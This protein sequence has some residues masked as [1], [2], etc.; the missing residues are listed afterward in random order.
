MRGQTVLP[1]V[2][3]E[4]IYELDYEDSLPALEG[5]L[6]RFQ[7]GQDLEEPPREQHH[8]V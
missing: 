6:H 8:P 5:A 7:Q 4:P 2:I 1:L 3:R